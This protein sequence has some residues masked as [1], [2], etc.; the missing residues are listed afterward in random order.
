MALIQ[1]RFKADFSID[2]ELFAIRDNFIRAVAQNFRQ[3]PPEYVSTSGWGPN[4]NQFA[5]VSAVLNVSW[6]DWIQM[7][8]IVQRALFDTVNDRIEEQN[9]AER[10]SSKELEMKLQSLN[11][12][13][14]SPFDALRSW[15]PN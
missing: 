3:T 13:K 4:I 2:P 8:P 15:G 6:S 10:K 11:E 12:N 14:G 1:E 5:H 9:R 7:D